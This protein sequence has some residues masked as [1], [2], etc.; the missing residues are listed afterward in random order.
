MAARGRKPKYETHV[1]RRLDDIKRWA[2]AGA[3][4]AEIC[5]ALGVSVSSFNLYKTQY[6]ELTD[7]L[8]AGRQTVVVEIK[9]AL[10]KKALGFKYQEKVG[11]SKGEDVQTEIYE[12]YSP[13]DTTAAAMLL[14]NY[15]DEWRDK[16]K[17]TAEFRRQEIA[18][19]KA[20][21]ES[22]NFDVNLT[23]I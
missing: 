14:R 20:L 10:Y 16:D 4:E 18:I 21:A 5:A 7:T 22:N 11:R 15:S 12:R 9:A 17:Q 1:K 23:N 19:K 13:P 6:S 8:R 2:A 3:T